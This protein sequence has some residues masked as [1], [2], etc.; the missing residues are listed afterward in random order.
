MPFDRRL[1]LLSGMGLAAAS[2]LPA[3]CG[4]LL[5][6]QW[7]VSTSSDAQGNYLAVALDPNGKL[8]SRV[9]LPARG[10]ESLALPHKP[11]HALVFARRPD[12]YLLEIDFSTGQVV[13][14]V[15]S[16]PDSHFYGHGT[17]SPD[18]KYL[19]SAE[20]N[21][22]QQR[23]M[24]V[25]RDGLTYQE[26]DRFDSGGIGPH[27]IKM[28][29]DAKHLVIANG[30]IAT[31]PDFHRIKLNLKDMQPNLA[32]LDISNGQIAATYKPPHH[33]Q[34]LRHLDVS[35]TGEV[36]VGVQFEGNKQQV[37]PL[38]YRHNGSE[39]LKPMRASEAL[40][41][42]LNYYTASVLIEQGKVAVSS[43]RGDLV[44]IWDLESQELIGKLEVGD[45]AGLA[46]FQEKM[47]LSSG[48]GDVK[49][50]SPALLSQQF[51]TQKLPNVRFDNHMTSIAAV[52]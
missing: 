1:F 11:G 31:H 22:H 8:I 45:A 23:G 24:I 42:Q 50:L 2:L 16:Q 25:V 6:Q 26:L 35:D 4:A 20:N 12:R 19:F 5:K 34:S 27:E 13:R 14:Q 28:M 38:I 30:G 37:M 3:G 9:A 32:Y 52:S 47:V 18:G 36:V 44:T 40:W 43:P 49:Y 15:H 7:L 48:Q 46:F 21:F 39:Q 33:Q 29:P 51:V 10:H 17:W 41:R